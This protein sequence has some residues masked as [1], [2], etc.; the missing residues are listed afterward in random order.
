MG[1]LARRLAIGSA[2]SAAVLAVAATQPALATN[3]GSGG[4]NAGP[5]VNEISLGNNRFHSY[6]FHGTVSTAWR[7]AMTSA[8]VDGYD[9]TNINTSQIGNNQSTD[10][11]IGTGVYN[12]GVYG[13][14]N[15]PTDGV[16]SGTDPSERCW[17][18]WLKIDTG[19]AGSFP[20][21]RKKSLMCH[22]FGHTLGL[23]HTPSGSCM[24]ETAVNP[25]RATV[26]DAH[27]QA[28]LNDTANYPL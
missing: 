4:S 18:Q 19:N 27:D 9:P 17:N 23:R 15:C 24:T 28:H 21:D 26:P 13:W 2:G 16:R 5:P 10:V 11:R 3:F 6:S 12:T 22:E 20:S 14:V 1:K 25:N 8:A 7:N